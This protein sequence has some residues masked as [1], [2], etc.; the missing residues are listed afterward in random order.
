MR[1]RLRS[2]ALART[3]SMGMMCSCSSRQA[4]HTSA[5]KAPIRPRIASHQMYQMMAKPQTVAKKATMTPVG[6]FTG[7]SIGW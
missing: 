7:I 4:Y 5:A 2:R 1:M 3:S 6:V